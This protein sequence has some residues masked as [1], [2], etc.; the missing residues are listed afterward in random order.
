MTKETED[1]EKILQVE[2]KI[3]NKEFESKLTRDF[4]SALRAGVP[5]LCINTQDPASVMRQVLKIVSN[6]ANKDAFNSPLI[7][8][9]VAAGL[10]HLN[11]SGEEMIQ[12]LLQD[13]KK[14][15]GQEVTPEKITD[16]AAT[17]KLLAR[18]ERKTIVFIHNAH[19]FVGNADLNQAIVG[20][21]IWNLRDQFK[22]SRRTLVLLSQ[23]VRLPSE[24]SQDVLILEDPLPT[25]EELRSIVDGMCKSNYEEGKGPA[26][27]EKIRAVEAV[28]G[29][30]AFPAEQVIAMSMTRTGFDMDRLWDRKKTAVEQVPGLRIWQ[31]K[32]TF[33]NVRGVD[34]IK[35]YLRMIMAGNDPPTVFVFWD[36]LEKAFAGTRGDSSGVS[37]EMHGMILSWMADHEVLAV[38]FAGVQ[39]CSKSYIS[40]AVAGEYKKPLIINNLS[41]LKSKYVGS[42][43]S[44]LSGALKMISAVGKPMVIATCNDESALS[45]ELKDRFNLGTFFF[46]LP[47]EEERA[48][49][50]DVWTK[51]YSL[52]H[53]IPVAEKIGWTARN[54]HDCCMLSW[55]L[56]ITLEQASQFIVPVVRSDPGRIEQLRDMANGK[57]LSSSIPGIYYKP[58]E[59]KNNI[60]QE[61]ERVVDTSRFDA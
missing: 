42:S 19:R 21:A 46:D 57:Y 48:A 8:W 61:G 10:G 34:N 18:T 28:R 55:K 37:Q 16:P 52:T 23:S 40:K 60:L 35:T 12:I 24:L 38:R 39:G 11:D 31:G 51:F 1:Q 44:Q 43:T 50:W 30:A 27:D 33:N 3:D 47:T 41:E 6:K 13:I 26:E 14:R 22:A 56:K 4:K 20:Q 2:A 49:I 45:S 29:L 54:I 36:E 25:P 17:I 58:K 9:D 59:K 53:P 7:S 5:L 32:E 15:T